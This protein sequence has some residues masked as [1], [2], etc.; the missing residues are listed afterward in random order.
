MSKMLNHVTCGHKRIL[1]VWGY[2]NIHA[3]RTKFFFYMIQHENPRATAF[4]WRSFGDM[5]L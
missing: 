5:L 3:G 1:R 2:K 4:S